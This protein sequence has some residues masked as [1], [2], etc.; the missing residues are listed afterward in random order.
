MFLQISR[1]G[2]KCRPLDTGLETYNFYTFYTL[3]VQDVSNWN[4]G[5]TLN[6]LIMPQNTASTLTHT[7][8]TLHISNCKPELGT[9]PLNLCQVPLC[10]G[11]ELLQL[12][13][14]FCRRPRPRDSSKRSGTHSRYG[15]LDQDLQS[16]VQCSINCQKADKNG[17]GK[18][19]YEEYWNVVKRSGVP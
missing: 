11:E 1:Q 13:C 12:P 5:G 6:T 4:S 10:R 8:D 19:S 16:G 15:H 2:P 18:L 17:D 9:V 7:S 3:Q 14:C